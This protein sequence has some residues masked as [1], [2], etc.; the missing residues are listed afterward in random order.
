MDQ[1]KIWWLPIWIQ[2]WP[3]FFFH[4]VDDDFRDFWSNATFLLADG[5]FQLGDGLRDHLDSIF[6]LSNPR[7]KNQGAEEL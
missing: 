2:F 3:I 7:G 1:L 6:S 5:F 4:T